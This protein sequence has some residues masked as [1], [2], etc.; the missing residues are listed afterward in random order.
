MQIQKKNNSGTIFTLD[1]ELLSF[2]PTI[3]FLQR[4]CTSMVVSQTMQSENC[5]TNYVMIHPLERNSVRRAQTYLLL[6]E[7]KC[8]LNGSH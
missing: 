3:S 6:P 7:Y 4:V 5:K 8:A 2:F 1:S